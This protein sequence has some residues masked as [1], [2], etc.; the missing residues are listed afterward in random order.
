[1]INY[2]DVKGW[3]K[4]VVGTE[5]VCTD[6]FRLLFFLKVNKHGV[7]L[8]YRDCTVYAIKVQNSYFLKEKKE[9]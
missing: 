4:Y 6:L 1:M 2:H 9:E 7:R 5:R 8:G 3:N